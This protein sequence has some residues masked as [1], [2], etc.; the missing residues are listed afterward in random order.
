MK[1]YYKML[2][3][4]TSYGSERAYEHKINELVCHNNFDGDPL[5]NFGGFFVADKSVILRFL[6]W[7]TTL[8]EVLVPDNAQIVEM[9]GG[10]VASGVYKVDKMILCNPIQLDDSM[11]LELIQNSCLS[12][13]AWFETASLCALHGFRESALCIINSYVNKEN[14]EEALMRFRKYYNFRYGFMFGHVQA[15]VACAEEIYRYLQAMCE[16]FGVQ[17]S[18]LI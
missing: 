9:S 2:Y 8:Y 6:T 10:A 15:D 5:H 17:D 7:G 3:G 13:S 4:K 11:V 16:G 18:Y 14:G 1:K 12:D